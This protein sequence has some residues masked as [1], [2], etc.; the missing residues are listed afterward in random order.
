MPSADQAARLPAASGGKRLAS[1]GANGLPDRFWCGGRQRRTLSA[2]RAVS[3]CADGSMSV[4][5]P[6][7][8]DR[9]MSNKYNMFF[10]HRHL[11]GK[12][13]AAPCIVQTHG[14]SQRP[15]PHTG[16]TAALMH[17]ALRHVI[18]PTTVSGDDGTGGSRSD[19]SS[20][21]SRRVRRGGRLCRTAEDGGFQTGA[22][23][24]VHGQMQ[25]LHLRR[26]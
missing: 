7:M 12:Y 25:L 19:V 1:P 9:K 2:A 23:G 3:S 14:A 26:P 13:R 5:S 8:N 15:S 20:C 6:Y 10:I 4:F 24:V 18:A 21:P 16:S 17:L 22:K 11:A